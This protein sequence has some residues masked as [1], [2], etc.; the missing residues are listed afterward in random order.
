[1]ER[2]VALAN[3]GLNELFELIAEE[4]PDVSEKV[5]IYALVP[6]SGFQLLRFFAIILRF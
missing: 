5:L 3:F 1:L 2:L 6:G 4:L